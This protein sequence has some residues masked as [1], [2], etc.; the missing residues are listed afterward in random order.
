M[1]LAKK[2]PECFWNKKNE[3]TPYLYSDFI[4]N[5]FAHEPEVELRTDT[6]NP[7]E[8]TLH[9]DRNF[10][11][12]IKDAMRTVVNYNEPGSRS[13]APDLLSQYCDQLLKKVKKKDCFLGACGYFLIR[14]LRKPLACYSVPRLIIYL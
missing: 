14:R 11:E 5:V 13:R 12:S 8:M 1:V 3:L 10:L 4:T 2:S 7:A 6:G 9:P